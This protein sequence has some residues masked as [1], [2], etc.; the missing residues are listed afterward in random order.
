ML[1]SNA[2]VVDTSTFM[3]SYI[4]KILHH[5]LGF[6]KIHEAEDA[7]DAFRVLKSERAINWIFSSLEMPGML[8]PLDLMETARNGPN[9]TRFIL[10]SSNEELVTREIAIR[11]GVADYLCKPFAP[12]QL[13]NTVHRLAGLAKRRGAERFKATLSCEIDIG[14]DS[15]HHYGAELADISM[16][17]CRIKTSQVKPDSGYVDDYATVTLL[18]ENGS[19]LHVQAKIKRVELSESCADP[20]SNTEMAVEFV[21][22]IPSLKEKLESFICHV[23]GAERH[24]LPAS[25]MS[26]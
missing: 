21:N 16:T 10:M 7:D 5:E 18:L 22:V 23:S 26:R 17:G 20:L 25:G 9:S 6:N 24:C 8:S 12:G 3:R 14:F 11:E 4:R 19:P 2:L 15:F 1:Q 13:V